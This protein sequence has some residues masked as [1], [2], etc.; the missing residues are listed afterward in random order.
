MLLAAA[1]S[2]FAASCSGDI[3]GSQR[4]PAIASAEVVALRGRW[5][6][7]VNGTITSATFSSEA[8]TVTYSG[9]RLTLR[10]KDKP[11][12][13]LLHVVYTSV[14]SDGTKSTIDVWYWIECKHSQGAGG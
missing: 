7:T 9:N 4:M 8:A 6:L 10:C 2:M 13:G 11:G 3:T 12:E 14:Q 5:T 1:A